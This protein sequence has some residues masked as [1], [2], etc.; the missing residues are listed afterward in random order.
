MRLSGVALED[1]VAQVIALVE[2]CGAVL[3]P[4]EDTWIHELPNVVR[5]YA[6][7]ASL[8]GVDAAGA[9]TLVVRERWH[10]VADDRFE[11]AEDEYELRDH[12][13]D[14]RRALHLPDRD[15]FVDRHLVVVHEHCERPVG[16]TPCARVEGRPVRDAFAGVM[17]LIGIW[18]D[19][20]LPD[21]AVLPCLDR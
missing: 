11:R 2:R 13:C 17:R 14:V 20:D 12:E 1:H 4:A 10:R 18:T 6:L 15:R 5:W 16:V 3:E 8:P 9:S 19:P 7:E 21:C